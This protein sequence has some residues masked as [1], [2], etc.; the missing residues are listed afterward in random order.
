MPRFVRVLFAATFALAVAAPAARPAPS[1]PVSRP[2]LPWLDLAWYEAAP[3]GGF[4]AGAD[5]WTLSGGA[6]VVDG[7]QP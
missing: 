6:A 3:D 7:G 2:F 1:R 4:E 5:G